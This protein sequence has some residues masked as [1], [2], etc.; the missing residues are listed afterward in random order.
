[1]RRRIAA[2]ETVPNS[3]TVTKVR[4][5]RRFIASLC[6]IGIAGQA[7][8]VLD[9]AEL[10]LP[11]SCRMHKGAQVQAGGTEEMH[12]K[13][14]HLMFISALGLTVVSVEGHTQPWPTKP[15]RAIVPFAAG[16]LTDILP[17]LVFEEL[18]TRLGQSIIV[19]NRPGPGRQ[20]LPV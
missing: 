7:N 4:A 9:V 3:A 8:Y 13:L 19:E 6:R 16:T 2:L 5:Y 14:S 10:Q 11:L 1:M 18:S 15:V 12:M 20:P 17:R